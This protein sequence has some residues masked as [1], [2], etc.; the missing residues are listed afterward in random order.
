M[1]LKSVR[2]GTIDPGSALRTIERAQQRAE[3]VR[4]LLRRLGD[5]NEGV[6]LSV[7]FNRLKRR[8]ERD[9]RDEG[10]AADFA[11]LTLAVHELNL[12]LSTKFY[13]EPV[14]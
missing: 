5:T 7:R 1:Q 11:Q 2:D 6:A 8:L 13:P 10:T 3:G 4:I 12:L 9:C 14:V